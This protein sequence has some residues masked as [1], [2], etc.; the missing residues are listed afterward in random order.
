MSCVS[1]KDVLI[2][3]EAHYSGQQDSLNR[4]EIYQAAYH[5]C[6]QNEEYSAL[7]L[8]SL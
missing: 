1:A 6:M 8:I 7:L 4:E 2:E 5:S 3:R